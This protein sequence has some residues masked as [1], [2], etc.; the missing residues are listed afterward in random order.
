MSGLRV[1]LSQKSVSDAGGGFYFLASEVHQYAQFDSVFTPEE[2]EAIINI[3]NDSGLM[4]GRTGAGHDKKTRDS[5]VSFMY[6]NDFTMWIFEK[7]TSVAAEANSKFFRFDLHGFFQGLQ[8]TKYE[9]PGNHYSWHQDMG[10]GVANRKLS[11]SVQ[12]SEPDDYEGGNLQLLS[13]D[14]PYT[15]EPSIGRVSFFPSWMVHR[16]TPVTKGTRY[17]LV[18]WISGPAFK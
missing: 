10:S 11:L 4:H 16:V 15:V 6:P 5:M 2:V 17:S 3:G 14:S 9:A 12:L 13:G 7:L 18:G 8:F 1:N